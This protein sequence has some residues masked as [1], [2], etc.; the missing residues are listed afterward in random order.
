MGEV[1]QMSAPASA[2]DKRKLILAAQR[3]LVEANEIDERETL[4]VEDAVAWYEALLPEVTNI[5]HIAGAMKI[6][7]EMR[8]GE[9]LP[10]RKPTPGH[11]QHTTKGALLC[12]HSRADS[13]ATG[14]AS[15]RR[16]L[17]ENRPLVEKYYKEEIARGKTPTKTGALAKA[18][19]VKGTKPR[20]TKTL[21]PKKTR[22]GGSPPIYTVIDQ[23]TAAGGPVY[24]QSFESA[25]GMTA[26]YLI[27]ACRYIPWVKIDHNAT[28]ISVSIDT[29]L[30]EICEGK[31]PRPEL[32]TANLIAFLRQTREEINR[33]RKEYSIARNKVKWDHAT[34]RVHLIVDILNWLDDEL[35]KVI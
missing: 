30:R 3:E 23:L 11:N 9:A 27:A 15:A 25:Y 28:T 31:R 8:Q 1:I 5:E 6:E 20:Q 21:S 19:A 33:R 13:K 32:G 2:E 35:N 10:P 29:E 26:P 4:S 18:R 34:S 7:M 22:G 14:Q 17:A 24:V 16:T 12:A